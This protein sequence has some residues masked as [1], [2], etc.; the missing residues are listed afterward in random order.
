MTA[1]EHH[2][3][4]AYLDNQLDDVAA[5]AFELL[6][7]ER[8]DLA[9]VVY[10]DAALRIGLGPADEH[11]ASSVQQVCPD[12]GSGT[13]DHPPASTSGPVEAKSIRRR[14]WHTRLLSP[15]LAAS[16]TLALGVGA[17]YSLRAPAPMQPAALAY[18]DKLRNGAS[19]PAIVLPDNGAVVLLAPVAGTEPCTAHV[20]VSQPGRAP[21]HATSAADEYGYVSLVVP[22]H[23]L[24]LGPA[25]VE[26]RCGTNASVRYAVE[27]VSSGRHGLE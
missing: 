7:L 3:L 10:A 1:L 6:L 25:E 27:L 16:L 11:S 5:E 13:H 4:K 14:T 2:L 17:G 23:K 19:E 24:V 18:I 9:E 20:S 22:R 8:P 21:M 12:Y 15:A 26:V